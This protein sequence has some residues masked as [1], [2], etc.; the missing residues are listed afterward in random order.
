M[1]TG[2]GPAAPGRAAGAVAAWAEVDGEG[3]DE[4]EDEV[5][6][7]ERAELLPFA[8]AA[9]PLLQAASVTSKAPVTTARGD[10]PRRR[11]DAVTGNAS[12]LSPARRLAPLPA[13]TTIVA[14]TPT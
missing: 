1:V 2:Q 3:E 13:P 11:V 5:A 6:A 8:V 4:D 9:E 7:D 10:G 14:A 12:I